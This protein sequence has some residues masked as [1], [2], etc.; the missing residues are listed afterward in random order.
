MATA[1]IQS[2]QVPEPYAMTVPLTLSG[3][4]ADAIWATQSEE[5][6]RLTEGDLAMASDVATRARLALAWAHPAPA[7]NYNLSRQLTHPT[8]QSA[9]SHHGDR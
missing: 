2:P 9:E 3:S 7:L 5:N 8:Q 6:S 4:D 1:R